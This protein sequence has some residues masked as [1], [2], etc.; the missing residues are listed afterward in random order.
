DMS[1]YHS[2][3][4]D[5]VRVHGRQESVTIYEVFDGDSEEQFELKSLTRADWDAA[6]QLYHAQSFREALAGFRDLT[7]RNPND[8]MFGIYAARCERLIELGVPENWHG[9]EVYDSK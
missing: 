4:I 5:R 6:V 7:A 1:R 3:F 8:T 9:V 2:R